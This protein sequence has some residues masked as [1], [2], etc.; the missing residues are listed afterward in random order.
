MV[1]VHRWMSTSSKTG[2]T[3]GRERKEAVTPPV[4]RHLSPEA[5]H[6][7]NSQ[8]FFREAPSQGDHRAESKTGTIPCTASWAS[9]KPQ[10][11][12]HPTHT[13]QVFF[14]VHLATWSTENSS[15][16]KGLVSGDY[17]RKLVKFF[18]FL[19]FL[20]LPLEKF[21]ELKKFKPYK[22]INNEK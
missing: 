22:K 2:R 3:A 8:G 15:S 12:R 16:V 13:L 4:C 21:F 10:P 1:Q 6:L 5:W 18:I 11:P 9:S 17:A 19:T 7:E 20:N 14:P